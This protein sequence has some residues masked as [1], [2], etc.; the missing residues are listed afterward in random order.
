M[1]QQLI[2]PTV[3]EYGAKPLSVSWSR[4]YEFEK[5][6]QRV[7]FHM[8]GKGDTVKDGR[9]FVHGTL[10]DRAVRRFLDQET[11]QLPGQMAQYVDEL[12]DEICEHNDEYKIEWKGDPAE[13]RARVREI[14]K[15]VVNNLEPFLFARVIPFEYEP[16]FRFKVPLQIPDSR[17]MG[18][19]I[20][21]NGGMDIAVR[22][23]D[24]ISLYDLKATT[25][26]NY[27]SSG[28]MP[29]LIFYGI[30]WTL[31]FGDKVDNIRAAF[32][33][34]YTQV[35]YHEL[36][37]TRADRAHL[38]SRIIRFANA[39]WDEQPPVCTTDKGECYFCNCKRIC[40]LWANAF[41]QN[42]NDG[43]HRISIVDTAKQRAQARTE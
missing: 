37:V 39:I 25:N 11:E 18:R 13:D 15:T 36:N 16:E 23:P 27:I 41:T 35:Q 34:P 1:A 26:E 33:T 22:E 14:A 24:R 32:L 31:L 30:A 43:K 20:I 2:I 29:Q 8:A 6:H 7:V 5:C 10:A 38:M 3:D 28:I 19:T 9:R 42:D 21:L 12:W 40:P 4:L 17:G